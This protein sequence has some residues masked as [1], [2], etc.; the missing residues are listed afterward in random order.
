MER[1]PS[2]MHR[3]DNQKIKRILTDS[4]E[5]KSIPSKASTDWTE[6]VKSKHHYSTL[7]KNN[8]SKG[9]T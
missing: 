1:V 8:K 5:C 7:V 6:E 9:R 2:S 3:Y 4:T